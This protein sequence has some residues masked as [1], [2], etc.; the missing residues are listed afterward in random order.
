LEFLLKELI[1]EL[2]ERL[3]EPG[4]AYKS[5][6]IKIVKSDFSVESRE[7]SFSKY[8]IKEEGITS[9]PEGLLKK[10]PLND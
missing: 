3:S 8:Q 6:A 5:I 9:V 10:F 2:H 7:I 4:Y 1:R